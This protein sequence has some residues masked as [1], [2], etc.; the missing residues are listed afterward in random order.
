[1]NVVNLVNMWKSEK[2]TTQTSETKGLVNLVNFLGSFFASR[3]R[4]LPNHVF[5]LPKC[6]EKDNRDKRLLPS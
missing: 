3:A 1:M 4:M 2:V 5:T 6:R